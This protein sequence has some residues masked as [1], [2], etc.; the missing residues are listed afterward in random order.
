MDG[1]ATVGEEDTSVWVERALAFLDTWTVVELYGS[2]S[3]KVFRNDT[4]TDQYLNFRSNHPLEHRKGDVRTL[5]NRADRLVSEKT[6]L[7]KEKDHIRKALKVNG[8]LDWMLA[9]ARCLI[10]VTQ[11][12]KRDRMRRKKW[13]RQCQPPLR[14]LKAHG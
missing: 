8:Y 10:N 3:M 14:H 11:D 12:R 4:H 7:E 6:E 2:I 5:M 1:S 9:D 13:S